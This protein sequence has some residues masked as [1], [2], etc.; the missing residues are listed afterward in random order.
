MDLATYFGRKFFYKTASGARLVVSVP[1]L[2]ESHRDTTTAEPNQLPS[3]GG[4]DQFA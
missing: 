4:R 2:D 1:F 3:I